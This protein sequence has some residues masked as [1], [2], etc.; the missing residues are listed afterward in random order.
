MIKSQAYCFFVT[1][2]I[3]ILVHYIWVLHFLSPLSIGVVSVY[4]HSP[5]DW[6]IEILFSVFNSP[7]IWCGSAISRRF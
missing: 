6:T 4:I 5:T 7:M 3:F 2:C 1:Q